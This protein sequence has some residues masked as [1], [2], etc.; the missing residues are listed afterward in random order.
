MKC[1]FPIILSVPVGLSFQRL[2]LA[3][4]LQKQDL[5]M[6]SRANV[7]GNLAC[8]RSL[9][10]CNWGASMIFLGQDWLSILTHTRKKDLKKGANLNLK[11]KGQKRV[12]H[13]LSYKLILHNCVSFRRTPS[14]I[15]SFRCS[16]TGEKNMKATT[17]KVTSS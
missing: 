8:K 9:S 13:V 16:R 17:A 15:L 14:C 7:A 3:Q 12:Y 4:R 5:M 11:D 1:F 2:S 10:F 6:S